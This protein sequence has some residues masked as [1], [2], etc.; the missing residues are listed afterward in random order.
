MTRQI[1]AELSSDVWSLLETSKTK[2]S[3][4][5]KGAHKWTRI[6]EAEVER[7]DEAWWKTFTAFTVTLKTVYN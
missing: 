3:F 5:L 1:A 4:E 6:N 7:V 2:N